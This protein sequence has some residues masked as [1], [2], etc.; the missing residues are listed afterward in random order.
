MVEYSGR[1]LD[2]LARRIRADRRREF[3]QGVFVVLCVLACGIVL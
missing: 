3:W 2:T 1:N